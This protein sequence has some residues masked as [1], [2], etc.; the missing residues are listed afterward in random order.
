MQPS[1]ILKPLRFS[2]THE[3]ATWTEFGSWSAI[4]SNGCVFDSRY[5]FVMFVLQRKRK[6][7]L[8]SALIFCVVEK[9]ERSMYPKQW[10]PEWRNVLTQIK[11]KPILQKLF[12]FGNL[13]S[14]SVAVTIKP[15][16]KNIAGFFVYQKWLVSIEPHSVVLVVNCGGG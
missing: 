13:Q 8:A 12:T 9:K 1:K 10:L 2:S 3:S 4:V 14:L 5:S 7:I 11:S 15:I 6:A 16:H